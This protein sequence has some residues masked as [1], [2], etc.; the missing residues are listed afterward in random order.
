MVFGATLFV[1]FGGLALAGIR[2]RQHVR[3]RCRQAPESRGPDARRSLSAVLEPVRMLRIVL[4]VLHLLAL[5]FGMAAI[6]N[7]ARALRRLASPPA[8]RD[9]FIADSWWGVSALLWIS[10]GLMRW[11]LGTEKPAAY[12]AN[13]HVFYAKM[14]L[15]VVI[16]ALEIWPMVTLIRWRIARA[17]GSLP[18]VEHLV[19]LGKRLSMISNVQ[20][21]LVIGMVIAA[22]LMA[23]GF[24]VQ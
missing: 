13:N 9:A 21:V 16:L 12:Y 2:A 17:R 6:D 24:G 22:V 18:P 1:T 7:R 10:T 19:P 11:L 5:G 3:V 20:G 14:G 4:A 15:L 23:R 8:L